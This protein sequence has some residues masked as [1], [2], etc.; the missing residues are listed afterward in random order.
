MVEF[1]QCVYSYRGLFHPSSHYYSYISKVAELPTH[2]H[3]H[4]HTQGLYNFL[5]Q[6]THLDDFNELLCYYDFGTDKALLL[7]ILKPGDQIQ[8]QVWVSAMN[9]RMGSD[10]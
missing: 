5:Y 8:I 1:G 10:R 3:T 2:T 7:A 9:A 6:R 4:T